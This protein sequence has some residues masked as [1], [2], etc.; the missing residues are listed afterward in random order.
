MDEGRNWEEQFYCEQKD[1]QFS[2][3]K[4]PKYVQIQIRFKFTRFH[5]NF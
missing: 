1:Q 5:Y 4:A 2:F 3:I